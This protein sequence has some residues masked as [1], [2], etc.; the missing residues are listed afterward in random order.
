MICRSFHIIVVVIALAF[1]FVNSTL[2]ASNPNLVCIPDTVDFGSI[3][4]GEASTHTFLLIDTGVAPAYIDSIG[5]S[6]KAEFLVAG[7]LHYWLGAGDTETYLVTFT[8][9]APD[10]QQST[11]VI[12]DSDMSGNLYSQYVLLIGSSGHRCASLDRA[13]LSCVCGFEYHYFASGHR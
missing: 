12:A 3:I 6:N 11:V 1:A 7:R 9:N 13:K 10:S 8:P 5:W 2:A 4:I